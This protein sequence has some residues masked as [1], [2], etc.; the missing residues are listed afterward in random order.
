MMLPVGALSL[1]FA[2]FVPVIDSD[3]NGGTL[4]SSSFNPPKPLPIHALYNRS[5]HWAVDY[6]IFCCAR[7]E[8]R[9]SIC[10]HARTP[11]PSHPSLLCH[12][13]LSAQ[14]AP[15]LLLIPHSFFCFPQR[16]FLA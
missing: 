4:P 10:S 5:T 16:V 2:H 3:P 1:S 11:L 14:P 13:W 7:R 12:L 8:K 9:L 15:P 6:G